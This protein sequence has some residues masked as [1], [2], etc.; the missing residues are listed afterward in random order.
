MYHGVVPET[1]SSATADQVAAAILETIPRSM[2]AIREQ[3]RSGRRAGLSIPQ[4]RLMR[5][6]R[7]N[8]GT[9]LS[10]VAD[11]LGTTVPATSQMVE[12][13]V[14]AGLMTRAQN[15]EERRQVELRLTE[16]GAATLK[17]LD[18]AT[19]AWLCERL[20]GMDGRELEAMADALRQLRSALSDED[21]PLGSAQRVPR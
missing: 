18:D 12:R 17:E 2:R 11:H 7:R 10:P 6:V 4:F 20:S 15:P 16:A 13:L 21:G 1:T 5:Y 14:R 9:S 19:R 3:M 8:P